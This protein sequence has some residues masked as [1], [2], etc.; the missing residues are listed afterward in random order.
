MA[1][2]MTCVMMPEPERKR[3]L[4]QALFESKPGEIATCEECDCHVLKEHSVRWEKNGRYAP[5]V[6]FPKCDMP[7]FRNLGECDTTSFLIRTMG[8]R[9]DSS[10]GDTQ[11]KATP[12]TVRE[13]KG[14]TR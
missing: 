13:T 2:V 9:V 14:S 6:I 10:N 1:C 4:A 5:T 3:V 12:F 11:P 7:N 8:R